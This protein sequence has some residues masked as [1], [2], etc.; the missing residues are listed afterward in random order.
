[1]NDVLL[2]KDFGLVLGGTC[3]TP[4]TNTQ[5]HGSD[6]QRQGIE[7]CKP[8]K[9][10]T[11]QK[12]SYF[13]VILSWK[14]GGILNE[15]AIKKDIKLMALVDWLTVSFESDFDYMLLIRILNM[16]YSD[17]QEFRGSR[18]RN[19]FRLS[20]EQG[21]DIHYSVDNPKE[22]VL[23]ISG[24]GCRWL[25]RH[26]RDMQETEVYQT[27]YLRKPVNWFQ[28]LNW[29]LAN[30]AYA[31]TR[32]DLAIDDFQGYLDIGNMAKLTDNGRTTQHKL[33]SY[34]Y[35]LS[36]V[37]NRGERT[38]QTLYLGKPGGEIVFRFYDKLAER[39]AKNKLL[40]ED[41]TFWNRYEVCMRHKKA[42]ELVKLLASGDLQIGPTVMALMKHYLCFKQNNGK[43]VN[44]SR[45]KYAKW[46]SDFLC[47]VEPLKLTVDTK[48]DSFYKSRD[49]VVETSS[50]FSMVFDR[51]VE[52]DEVIHELIELGKL[53]QTQRH[54]NMLQ[55][56]PDS[57][58]SREKER[59]QFLDEI[60]RK[61]VE[62]IRKRE[63]IND[64]EGK[65]NTSENTMINE[66]IL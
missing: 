8:N 58:F 48:E 24:Q 7:D 63:N 54:K 51:Y 64:F 52:D 12:N 19:E 59:E 9:R 16:N 36:G 66:S 56:L 29:L 60:R 49:W 32:I 61:K 11:N 38:G 18:F 30:E 45:W 35:V 26:W 55:A 28:L 57:K 14:V 10:G 53:K 22:L 62:I 34:K 31:F 40:H 65:K 20:S 44:I 43:G 33:R 46:W 15:I 3:N 5:K 41:I 47:L 13:F 23:D 6:L 37:T 21:I 4:P 39:Q 1:M 2:L 50:T 17:F 42:T 25:E 27:G